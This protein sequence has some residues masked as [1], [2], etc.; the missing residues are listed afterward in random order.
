MRELTM[1]EVGIVGGGATTTVCRRVCYTACVP[2]GGGGW[3]RNETIC[4]M[5]CREEEVP[6]DTI[7]I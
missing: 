6:D 5:V 7:G 3:C 1:N 2:F 4:R